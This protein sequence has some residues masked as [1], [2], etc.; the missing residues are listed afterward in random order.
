MLCKK[1]CIVFNIL[2]NIRVSGPRFPNNYF[3]PQNIPDVSQLIFILLL[4]ASYLNRKNISAAL[5]KHSEIY[6]LHISWTEEGS[7]NRGDW[8]SKVGK[9]KSGPNVYRIPYWELRLEYSKDQPMLTC[10]SW[11]KKLKM[12]A[13]S[14]V[15]TSLAINR[16]CQKTQVLFLPSIRRFQSRSSTKSFSRFTLSTKEHISTR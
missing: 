2:Y 14:E 10:V 13:V 11:P 16:S 15:N 5:C 8:F 9:K 3:P 7:L 12:T 4:I 1:N 6:S